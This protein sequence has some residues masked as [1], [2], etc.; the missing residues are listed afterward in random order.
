MIYIDKK[1]VGRKCM[2]VFPSA[3]LSVCLCVWMCDCKLSIF[4]W[5]PC[6]LHRSLW[7]FECIFEDF[8]LKNPIDFGDDLPKIL[9]FRLY[10]R[11]CLI[12]TKCVFIWISR[13]PM[14]N[15]YLKHSSINSGHQNV[16][17]KLL[18]SLLRSLEAEICWF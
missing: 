7:N 16:Q 15:E 17:F 14:S 5:T 12:W 6:S 11:F 3:C 2:Y 10:C 18:Q 8:F 9:V 13:D 1:V 4:C